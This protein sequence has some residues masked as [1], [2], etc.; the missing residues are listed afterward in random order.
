MLQTA[1][2][3]GAMN[4]HMALNMWNVRRTYCVRL[5]STRYGS[6]PSGSEQEGLWR[7]H[8]RVEN[9]L[10]DCW[11]VAAPVTSPG[12]TLLV[13][14]RAQHPNDSALDLRDKSIRTVSE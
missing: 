8:A 11:G 7:L 2:A 13:L 9:G 12:T 6:G 4:R 3:Q 10:S 14:L 1:R 5:K